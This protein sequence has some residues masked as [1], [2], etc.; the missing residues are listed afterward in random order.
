M[1]DTTFRLLRYSD[2]DA[3]VQIGVQIDG[4]VFNI[5][6]HFPLISAW[7]AS[8]VGRVTE[9]IAALAWLA[10]ASAGFSAS[11]LEKAPNP[12]ALHLLAPTYEQDVWAA[13]VTYERSREARQEES[14]D[15][16]NVY[17][18]V[19]AA[20]RPEL[21]FKAHGRD[22]V[23]HLDTVGIRADS[24]WNVPE[25]ELAVVLNPALEIIGFTVGNDM[26]SRDIEGEN[27]LYLPQAKVYTRACALGPSI[28][29]NPARE[30]PQ[31]A[32]HM[33]ISRDGADVFTGETH[34]RRIRRP[35][36]ELVQ[37]LGRANTFPRGAVL[38]TG[39]GI[40]P[41]ND[42]TLQAGDRVRIEIE[43]IGVLENAVEVV[44]TP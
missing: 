43:N 14:Q 37:Y 29:L 10:D 20:T 32:I 15:G 27:P 5:S 34:T 28:L 40:V 44:G 6:A 33:S 25:P 12:D 26:S 19:Y 24:A 35:L 23:G 18:R 4:Q 41:P 22:A 3:G 9:A 11:A 7:L 21:F 39:T 30:F 31:A 8:S 17:A 16:G 36:A 38:L 2:P 1:A 42:F 13:G